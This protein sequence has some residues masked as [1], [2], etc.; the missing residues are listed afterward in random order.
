MKKQKTKKA[1]IITLVLITSLSINVLSADNFNT[2]NNDNSLSFWIDTFEDLSLIDIDKSADYEL[3]INNQKISMKNTYSSWVDKNFSKMKQIDISNNNNFDLQNVVIRLTINYDTNMKQDYSDLRFK[4]QNGNSLPHWIETKNNNQANILVTIT[5]LLSFEIT[6]IY[7]FYDNSNAEDISDFNNIFTWKERNSSDKMISFKEPAEGAWDP[8]IEYGDSEFLVVWEERLGPE[9]IDL[10]LDNFER[11]I[12]GVIHGRL[13]DKNGNNPYPDPQD[14]LDIDISNPNSTN[15]HAENPSIAYGDE[16]FFI[17]WEQNP[18]NLPDERYDSDIVGALLDTDGKIIKRINICANEEGQFNPK[19]T[20]NQDSNKFFIIWEDSRKGTDDYDIRGKIYTNNGYEYQSVH[21]TSDNKNEKNAN[22]CT[23]NNNNYMIVYNSGNDYSIGPFDI[24]AKRFDQTGSLIGSRINIANGN[25]NIDY[26]YPSVTFNYNS[27]KFFISWNDGDISSDPDIINNYKGN[28]WGKI[29]DTSG[30]TIK[31]NFIIR[32]GDSYIK[33]EVITYFNYHFFITYDGINNNNQDIWGRII[34][35]EGEILTDELQITD[36]S[37]QNVKNNKITV[38]NNNIFITWEDQRDIVS[39]YADVFGYIWSSKQKIQTESITINIH[40][41]KKLIIESIIIS[42]PIIPSEI[43]QWKTFNTTYNSDFGDILFDITDFNGETIILSNIQNEENISN[44]IETKIRLKATMIRNNPTDT[45]FINNWQVSWYKNKDIKSPETQINI[46]PSS[47]NGK[48]EWYISPIEI[49]F[50]RSDT[51][52]PQENIT[53]F[54]KINNQ[55]KQEYNEIIPISLD[56]NDINNKVEYW[57]I[58][59]AGNEEKP[60][61]LINNLKIDLNQPSIKLIKPAD[62]IKPGIITINISIEEL[63]S[64]S[65]LEKIIITLNNEEIFNSTIVGYKK[66]I[67]LSTTVE[68]NNNYDL[69][70]IAFDKAGNK[71]QY[72]KQFNVVQKGVY[73]PGYIYI[74]DNP[75]IGPGFLLNKY[76]ITMVVNKTLYLITNSIDNAKSAEFI[77]KKINKNE[78]KSII[79]TNS[80]NGF[81]IN[82]NLQTGFYEIIVEFFD[83]NDNKIKS[84]ILNKKMFFISFNL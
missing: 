28:I 12:P 51:D 66:N 76:N 43:Y 2:T 36:N 46:I 54:Y 11:T 26:L 7:M 31:D 25:E 29:L 6:S 57:S 75:K 44:I 40:E 20:Y 55:N 67:E 56:Y 63:L 37:S 33:P 9:D 4:D 62:N 14:N 72:R 18:S 35:S 61:N 49:T 65:G 48:N 47:P 5:E 15:Y 30:I 84:E 79:D 1:I 69:K 13:Y 70:V 82:T 64:G 52:S 22:L 50:T 60:H 32:S 81:S 59:N 74:Y 41:E 34:S 73:E 17:V 53:T 21:V 58:D 38:G 8:H 16:K 39:Q 68:I 10:P 42:K 19:I 45:P 3:D 80:N 23:D 83:D 27:N 24:Y 77:I 78:N 71:G